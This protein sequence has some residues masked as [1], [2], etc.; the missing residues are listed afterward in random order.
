MSYLGGFLQT[1]I[2]FFGFFITIYNKQSYLVDL[3]NRLY[4]FE[5]DDAENP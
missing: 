1:M 4:D 5:V 2:V 3:S